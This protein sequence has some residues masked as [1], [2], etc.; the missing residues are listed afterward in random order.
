MVLCT[1]NVIQ[2][3]TDLSSCICHPFGYVLFYVFKAPKWFLIYWQ[4]A[5]HSHMSSY[6]AF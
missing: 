6:M 2:T 3:K 4:M 5:S 1:G